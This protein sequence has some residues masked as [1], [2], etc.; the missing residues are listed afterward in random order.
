MGTKDLPKLPS[1]THEQDEDS[2]SHMCPEVQLWGFPHSYLLY[3]LRERSLCATA[4]GRDRISDFN[5]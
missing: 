1:L 4:A 3:A 5:A 2:Q